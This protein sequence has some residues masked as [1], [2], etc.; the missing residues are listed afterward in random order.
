LSHK[1]AVWFGLIS[2]P[3]YLWHW[4]LLSFARIVEGGVPTLNLRLT[5]V[6]LSIFLAWLTFIF[7]EKPFRQKTSADK[8]KVAVLCASLFA[9]G[10]CGFMVA[11]A[12]LALSHGHEKL[13]IKRKGFEHALGSSLRFYRGKDDWLFLGNAFSR[14]VEKLKLTIVPKDSEVEA[15]TEIFS[16]IS[17]TASQFNT[18]VILI[19]GPN[20][21]SIY[22]EYLPDNLAP[23]TK[24]YSSFFLEKLNN[25]PNLIICNPTDDFILFKKICCYFFVDIFRQNFTEIAYSFFIPYFPG[26]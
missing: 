13:A 11:K 18:K 10:F 17:K 2:F 22:P 1:V 20:K 19:V 7:V 8:F 23:S 26:I 24:K 4:P 16:K 12:D 15:T 21:S 9:I 5:A 6:G 25:V 14:T 3:L